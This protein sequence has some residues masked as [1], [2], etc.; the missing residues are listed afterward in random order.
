MHEYLALAF[1]EKLAC[2]GLRDFC[3][4][5]VTFQAEAF[6][7]RQ[8]LGL[9]LR[10]DGLK[11]RGFGGGGL[12]CHAGTAEDGHGQG[13]GEKRLEASRAGAGMV[14]SRKFGFRTQSSTLNDDSKLARAR[15]LSR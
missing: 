15:F 4:L 9:V 5:A 3:E 1:S 7:Y 12:L 13:R 2:P 6:E 11:G 10:A 8:D 14:P